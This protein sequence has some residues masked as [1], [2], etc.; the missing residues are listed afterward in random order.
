MICLSSEWQLVPNPDPTP[1]A[2]CWFPTPINPNLQFQQ[3][4]RLLLSTARAG[5]RT[6]QFHRN[7]NELEQRRAKRLLLFSQGDKNDARDEKFAL[8]F[9]EISD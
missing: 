7:P 6:S 8:P 2:C 1:F 5:R 9:G 4:H 3:T